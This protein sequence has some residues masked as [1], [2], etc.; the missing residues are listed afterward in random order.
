MKQSATVPEEDAIVVTRSGVR[1]APRVR[2][3][4]RARGLLSRYLADKKLD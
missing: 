4:G 3:R 2:H 1:S